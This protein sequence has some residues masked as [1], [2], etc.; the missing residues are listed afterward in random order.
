MLVHLRV[1]PRGDRRDDDSSRYHIPGRKT[2]QGGSCRGLS[3]RICDRLPG[4]SRPPRP[5]RGPIRPRFRSG[6]GLGSALS[7]PWRV[8][9]RESVFFWVSM[10]GKGRHGCGREAANC[11]LWSVISNRL[12]IGC[13]ASVGTPVS[14][15]P[16]RCHRLSLYRLGHRGM[17]Y[18][19]ICRDMSSGLGRSDMVESE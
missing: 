9:R 19:L 4:S 11:P 3:V 18:H 7:V 1:G 12:S 13:V 15:W 6:S 17:G 5:R 2:E 14:A 10:C 8:A 16:G